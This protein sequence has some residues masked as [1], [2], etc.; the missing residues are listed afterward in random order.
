MTPNPRTATSIRSLAD[1]ITAD[2]AEACE[3]IDTA[4]A[5]LLALADAAGGLDGLPGVL[6]AV[7]R[8]LENAS[9]KAR[10]EAR[11]MAERL[12]PGQKRPA[13]RVTGPEV[14]RAISDGRD[15]V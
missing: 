5:E 2:T 13:I 1:S 10:D 15:V 8:E 9:D 11:A 12:V 7:A 14:E 6:R 3:R 4:R